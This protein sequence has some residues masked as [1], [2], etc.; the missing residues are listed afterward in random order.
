MIAGHLVVRTVIH[1]V[2]QRT[3]EGDTRGGKGRGSGADRDHLPHIADWGLR[4]DRA[5]EVPELRLDQPLH[6][7]LEDSLDFLS[8][9][10]KPSSAT[11]NAESK[12]G[13]S[14]I[15]KKRSVEPNVN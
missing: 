13:K 10:T 12:P 2:V 5:A 1:G 6:H 9:N 15:K 8:G 3:T 11:R 7:Y 14:R 4:R